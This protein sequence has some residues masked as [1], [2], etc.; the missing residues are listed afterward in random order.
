MLTGN[1]EAWVIDR[2]QARIGMSLVSTVQSAPT[3]GPGSLGWKVV[4]ADSAGDDDAVIQAV[5]TEKTWLAVVGMST[6]LSFT[7]PEDK[8]ICLLI[9][10]VSG[11]ATLRLSA[12]RAR[13]NTS[14][15]PSAAITMYYA[16]ARNEVA[17]ANFLLP[18][19]QGLL[20]S[21][22]ADYATGSA[23]RFLAAVVSADGSV[24]ATALQLV[25]QAPQTLAPAVGYKMVNL[26]PYTAPVAQAVT[27]VGQIYLCIFAFI[28]VSLVICCKIIY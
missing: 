24:N 3:K 9:P 5:L 7:P 11:N 13:G 17:T 15:D 19:A 27:L 6:F 16:Q 1:L 4:S 28:F 21:F 12:A 18:T 26:R 25:N 23:Q 22:C 2:D 20:S 8:L 14:Y 10:L